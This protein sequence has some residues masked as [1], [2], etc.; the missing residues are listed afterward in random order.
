MTATTEE[1]NPLTLQY[2][3]WLYDQVFAV[4]DVLSRHSYTLVCARMHRET[5]QALVQY[6]ENRIADGSELRNEFLKTSKAHLLYQTELI[7]ED[8]SVFEILVGLAIRADRMIEKS[9][10][11]WFWIFLTNLGLQK[12]N[13]EHVCVRPIY[14]VDRAIRKFNHRTYRAN[15][16][17]GIFPLEKP[18][19][20]QRRV[21]LWYQ[22]GAY[23]TE[24]KMY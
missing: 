6:D 2:F 16:V 19:T 23:M 15:G 9:V 7:Y 14:Q 17:G 5:F 24:N 3:N 12:F 1:N 21:E 22:M 8:A 20:D 10:S 4:R 18:L 13:D 11:D